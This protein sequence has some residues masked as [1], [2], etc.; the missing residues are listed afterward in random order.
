MNDKS[1]L[2][3]IFSLFRGWEWNAWGY[4]RYYFRIGI[5]I[6]SGK[7]KPRGKKKRKNLFPPG[8]EPGT[9]RVWGARDNHY[10]TETSLRVSFKLTGFV[11]NILADVRVKK[12]HRGRRYY[13]WLSHLRNKVQLDKLSPYISLYVP[14]ISQRLPDNTILDTTWASGTTTRWRYTAGRAHQSCACLVY[15]GGEWEADFC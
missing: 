14:Y 4:A 9:L 13:V 11:V 1:L 12:R 6:L 7:K 2:S 3:I 5:G 8:I 15:S 10:T